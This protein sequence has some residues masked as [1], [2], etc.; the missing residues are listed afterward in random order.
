MIIK[1][2]NLDAI[3]FNF[4]KLK[5]IKNKI[6]FPVVKNNAY[7]NGAVGII[8]E[9]TKEF[10]IPYFCVASVDEIKDK[11]LLKKTTAN[12]LVFDTPKRFIDSERITYS[13]NDK[14]DLFKIL[15]LN[16]RKVHIYFDVGHGRGS[17]TSLDEVKNIYDLCA[18]Y[19]IYVEGIYTHIRSYNDKIAL[20]KIKEIFSFFESRVRYLHAVSSE[21]LGLNLGNSIRIGSALFGDGLNEGFRQAISI[22]TKIRRTVKVKSGDTFGYEPGLIASENG[23]VFELDT[24]YHDGFLKEFAGLTLLVDGDLLPI[25]NAVTMNKVYIFSKKKYKTGTKVYVTKP[26]KHPI[27]AFVKDV[28]YGPALPIVFHETFVKWERDS[29]EKNS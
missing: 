15:K 11:N 9:L 10:S 2:V 17:I 1:S 19:D 26:V 22:Y 27:N 24:G 23:Y 20:D 21:C 25:T 3:V 5:K 28:F 13:I 12:F 16:H 8:N 6:I 18:D 7:G 4:K 29:D 14:K